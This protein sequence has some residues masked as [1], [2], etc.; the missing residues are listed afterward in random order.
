MIMCRSSGARGAGGEEE[1]TPPDG[2]GGAPP[3]AG[4]FYLFE[5]GVCHLRPQ[6]VGQRSSVRAVEGVPVQIVPDLPRA[7]DAA[8]D[9]QLVRRDLELS[10]RH[11]QGGQHPEV[12]AART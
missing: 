8:D 2:G 10:Q 5:S 11:L 3:P 7:T 9:E 4:G 12:T 6:G 1:P